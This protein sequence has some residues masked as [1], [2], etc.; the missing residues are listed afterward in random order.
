V[1]ALGDIISRGLAAA[2]P[3]AGTEGRLYYSTDTGILERDSG[4]A[5]ESVEGTL[6]GSG[7]APADATYITTSANGTLSAEVLLSAVIGRG[8][9]AS[10]PAFGTAGRLYYDTDASALYRDSGSAWELVEAATAAHD[11]T[12]AADGGVLTND[13]HD[14]YSEYLQI[15]TPG[16]PPS[17]SI[18]V[19]AKDKAGTATLYYIDEAGTEFELPTI[20]TGGGGGGSGA[21]ADA[22]Y[23]TTAASAGLSAEV[24][25]S[26]V[27]GSGLAASRPA[28]GT[29]GRL[30][31]AT[32]TNAISR[33]NGVGW[34]AWELDWGQITTGV[35]SSFTPSTHDLFSDRHPD[36]DAADT[37]ADGDVLTY[38]NGAGLWK[39]QALPAA[40]TPGHTIEEE[41]TPLT[42]RSKLN[43][44]G[45]GVTVTDDSGDDASVVTIPGGGGG[46]EATSIDVTDTALAL[47]EGTVAWRGTR[48]VLNLYDDTRERNM[49]AVGWQ[50]FAFPLGYSNNMTTFSVNLSSGG[51]STA[52]PILVASHLLLDGI[53]LWATDTS[54]ARECEW[55]LYEDRHNA[56]NSVDEIAS[57]NGTLS[58]T[59]TVGAKR[60]S[61]LGAP[62]YLGP[63]VYWL[64][65]RNT[66]GSNSFGVGGATAG[67]M[68]S[69]VHNTKTLV[70]ALGSTLDL[71]AATWTRTLGNTILCRLD[72]RVF[73][74]STPL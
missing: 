70:S 59:P 60:T 14:G 17:N 41:G 39:A 22:P 3:A 50:P 69:A 16:T 63:G 18:R 31:Y 35:P 40:S 20:V 46:G 68:T 26:A 4:S 33:D 58:F 23:I 13:E 28:A 53:T 54:L 32:D 47:T 43:F 27:V 44:V 2:R 10:R 71:V 45:A 42:A 57:A 9:T 5:W 30:Y 65:I 6:S 48:K 56:S 36:V 15:A 8:D 12:S 7:G 55:R 51:G 11:H 38:D 25:L 49:S 61:T 52:V 64:V 1:T 72:G 67:T 62:V 74:M 66:H 29:A 24:L 21:P 73:G 19:Y 34:D 37:P